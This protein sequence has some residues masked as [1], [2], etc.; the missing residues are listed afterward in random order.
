M[1]HKTRNAAHYLRT[2]EL[3]VDSKFQYIEVP[4]SELPSNAHEFN[5]LGRFRRGLGHEGDIPIVL[6]G[7]AKQWPCV[8]KWNIGYMKE[9]A[10]FEK[11]HFPHR[12]YTSFTKAAPNSTDVA[13]DKST[14]SGNHHGKTKTTLLDFLTKAGP[15]SYLVS[16]GGND[17]MS[18]I[19]RLSVDCQDPPLK[20]DVPDLEH[21]QLLR[22]CE[23]DIRASTGR[24]AVLSANQFFVV[25]GVSATEFHYDSEE[26]C[27]I[28]VVGEKEWTIAPPWIQSL[29][30]E[31]PLTNHC[32]D[33]PHATCYEKNKEFR[34]LFPYI[35]LRLHPGDALLLPAGW[36]HLV[37]SFAGPND[38]SCAF[39]FLWAC[40]AEAKMQRSVK[41]IPTLP[42]E[43]DCVIVD[44]SD[45]ICPDGV[46]PI[47]FAT[48]KN[49]V[50]REL[51][52]IL[53]H[54]H[55]HPLSLRRV[56]HRPPPADDAWIGNVWDAIGRFCDPTDA[57]C[58]RKR[59]Y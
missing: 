27:F 50:P 1:E 17:G 23:R 22:F 30:H 41:Y 2:V 7:Y 51:L 13:I 29:W 20:A 56:F 55:R 57:P 35:K 28:N 21:D 40:E 26:N 16:L 19:E 39:N 32:T 33:R 43:S 38:I 18:P 14:T 15:N 42:E 37:R 9:K 47:A 34:S 24:V 10:E 44:D 25:K 59:N 45:L 54:R 36:L 6:R 52:S 11:T 4:E 31:S 53:V 58:Y 3:A 48:V 49:L 5:I 46:L 12:K 8:Q